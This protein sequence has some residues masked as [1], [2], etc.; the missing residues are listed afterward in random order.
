MSTI[1]NLPPDLLMGMLLPEREQSQR[2][3]KAQGF[4][5]TF[6]EILGL[7]PNALNSNEGNPS[8][9]FDINTAATIV[10]LGEHP[11]QSPNSGVTLPDSL[12]RDGE[13]L[14]LMEEND[15]AFTSACELDVSLS[16]TSQESE[17]PNVLFEQQAFS[18]GKL[19]Y[20]QSVF[21]SAYAY[22]SSPMEADRVSF[23][24]VNDGRFET[25]QL[26]TPTNI[27]NE[28]FAHANEFN[29]RSG[30]ET[31]FSAKK[32][33]SLSSVISVREITEYLKKNSATYQD[34][35]FIKV[36]IRD[37][38]L[39]IADAEAVLSHLMATYRDSGKTLQVQINGK[40]ALNVNYGEG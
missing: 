26:A 35:R 10:S 6:L 34:E 3:T 16:L 27:K 14:P 32:L 23:N 4:D 36:T 8:S 39:T 22:T 5:Q 38:S 21:Q 11:V 20:L 13:A 33:S 7:N 17:L 31:S 2:G 1:G 30:T 37:Y 12:M 15:L 24:R 40:P 25:A 28:A 19:S 29:G 9:T 18:Q